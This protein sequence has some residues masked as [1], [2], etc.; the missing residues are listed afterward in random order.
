MASYEYHCL[1]CS[2]DF[3]IVE[4]PSAHGRKKPTCPKCRSIKVE[5]HFTAFYPKTVRKS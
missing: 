5:R 4:R 1:S 3:T 2:M